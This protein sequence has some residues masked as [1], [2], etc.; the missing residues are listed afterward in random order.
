MVGYLDRFSRQ[1]SPCHRLP[2]GTKLLLAF[3]AILGSLLLPAETWPGQVALLGLILAAQSVAKIPFGYVVHRVVRFLPFVVMF[4]FSIW[5]GSRGGNRD[6]VVVNLLLRSLVCFMAALW[7]VNIAPFDALLAA[8][9]R[10]GLP[11]VAVTLLGFMYRYLFVV[12]DELDRMRQAREARTFG[13]ISIVR[14]WGLRGQ[15]VGMLLVRG[16]SRAER[17]YGA[18][19]SRGWDGTIRRLDNSRNGEN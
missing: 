10:V 4:C 11:K 13:R 17:V 16:I 5:L 15:M 3:S 7:L 8:L 12:F 9:Q 2:T 18:M 6:V 19:C 1:D 14:Q